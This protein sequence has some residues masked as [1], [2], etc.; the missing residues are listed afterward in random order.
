MT[1][2]ESTLSLISCIIGAGIVSIPYAL[3]A[4]GIYN[5]IITNIVII[6]CLLFA[7]HL[8]IKSMEYLKLSAVSE[9][10]FMSMGRSSIYIINGFFASIFFGVLIMYNVLFS[11]VAVQ[12]FNKSGLVALSGVSKGNPLVVVL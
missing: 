9:L 8:Y 2:V 5:G 3:T 6:F 7:S 11:N 4:T 12:L 10:S 1:V